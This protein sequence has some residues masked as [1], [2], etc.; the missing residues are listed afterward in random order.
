MLVVCLIDLYFQGRLLHHYYAADIGKC[1]PVTLTYW[2]HRNRIKGRIFNRQIQRELA[3]EF[4][5][6]GNLIW[7]AFNR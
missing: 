5:G 4:S 6:V 3:W 7:I 2:K 1:W